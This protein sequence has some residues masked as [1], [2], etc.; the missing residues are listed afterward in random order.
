MLERIKR[1]CTD[2]C[3]RRP[4]EEIFGL[5]ICAAPDDEGRTRLQNLD[6]VVLGVGSHCER[7]SLANFRCVARLTRRSALRSYSP[8]AAVAPADRGGPCSSVRSNHC[9]SQMP[10]A[11]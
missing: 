10:L 2:G 4:R 5:A 9:S 7:W 11:G 6:A 3:D 1:G 8:C